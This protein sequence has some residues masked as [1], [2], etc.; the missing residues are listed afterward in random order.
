[1]FLLPGLGWLLFV[2]LEDPKPPP[3]RLCV[4]AGDGSA[5]G[6]RFQAIKPEPFGHD[7]GPEGQDGGAV[8]ADRFRGHDKLH[9][10]FDDRTAT[11]TTKARM[12]RPTTKAQ[13]PGI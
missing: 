6:E 8:D 13:N 3:F 7:G 1:M 5:Q 11:H 10:P 12:T 9:F 4:Q 2:R